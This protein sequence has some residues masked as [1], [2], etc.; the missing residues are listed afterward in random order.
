MN[1]ECL[2]VEEMLYKPPLLKGTRRP[3][4]HVSSQSDHEKQMTPN[5]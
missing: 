4:L 2:S 5:S 3:Q 1:I